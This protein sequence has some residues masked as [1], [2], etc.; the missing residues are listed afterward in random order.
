M[1]QAGLGS[2][3]ISRRASLTHSARWGHWPAVSTLGPISLP[4][5]MFDLPARNSLT[6][7]AGAHGARKAQTLPSRRWMHVTAAVH[8]LGH[9]HPHR[10]PLAYKE[11]HAVVTTCGHLYEKWRAEERPGYKNAPETGA[12]VRLVYV[13]TGM[14]RAEHKDTSERPLALLLTGSPGQYQDFSYTIPFL[15]RHG[16]DVLCF[17]W[18]SFS[19]TKR[20]GYWWH[21]S[22]EKTSLLSDFLKKLGIKEVDML[23][24]HSSAAFPAVQLTAE[25]TGSV[26]VKSL[27]LLMPATGSSVSSMRHPLL[28]NPLTD[29]LLRSGHVLGPLTSF[30]SSAMV[31]IR[32]PLR[33][34]MHDVY[35]AYLSTVGVD[36]A[37][38]ERQLNTLRQRGTPMVVMISGTDKLI[39]PENNRQLLRKLGQDPD[40]TWLYDGTGH[41]VRKGEPGVV[42]V[43]EMAKGSHYA[44]SRH[45]DICNQALLELLA[46][47]PRYPK[48]FRV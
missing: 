41:L 13:H 10:V 27:A 32:H 35:F 44:F 4:L 5:W 17:N 19:F 23:V 40:K 33:R 20:T 45:S 1:L 14:D 38:F 34:R 3:R 42:K 16:V 11:R 12:E 25:H 2:C 22:E 30:L 8:R 7:T 47:A 29:W 15:D 6:T 28:V 36:D 24:S 39:S 46:R 26:T 9:P 31:L 21:S 37:R 18:P 43:I 48:H